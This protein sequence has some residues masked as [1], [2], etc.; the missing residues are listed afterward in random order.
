MTNDDP[1]KSDDD[2]TEEWE[3]I[4]DLSPDEVEEEL[5]ELGVDKS[6]LERCRRKF[7][8]NLNKEIER[9]A[10]GPNYNPHY[11]M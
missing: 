10:L 7:M 8:E 11:K 9:S 3:R 6:D 2:L 4:C 5:R 1:I